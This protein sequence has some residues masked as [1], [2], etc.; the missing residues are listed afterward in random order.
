MTDNLK[1]KFWDRLQDTRAGMLSTDSAPAV[2]MSHHADKN[3]GTIWFITAKDTDLAKS[4]AASTRSQFLL[5]SADESLYARVDGA[6]EAVT[7]RNMLDEIWSVF[8]GAWFED[9]KDDPDIQLL[10]FTPREAEVWATDGSVSFLYEVA[11][12]NLTDSKPDAGD[13]GKLLF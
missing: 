2:P 1:E 12:A 4:A 3:S 9:G 13:H 11:K 7:D 6:L 5:S 10:R 8:A